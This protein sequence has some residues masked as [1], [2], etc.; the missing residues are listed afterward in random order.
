MPLS[1]EERATYEWQM[2]V[3]GFGESGQEKLKAA[4]VLV[5]RVGGLGGI[6]AYELAAAGIGE[7]VIAH[8]G[9]S[10]P[11]DLNRQLLQTHAALGK[12]RVTTAAERLRD[13]NP[14]L[15][16]TA[17]DENINEENAG[18]LIADVDIVVDCAPL[19]EE[20]FAMNRAA[21][22]HRKPLV[23]CAMYDLEATLTSI[24]PGRTP[25]LAC[26]H[27]EAPPAWKREFPVFGAVSGSVGCMAAMEAIKI[28]AG[29]GE[30]MLGRLLRYDLREMTFQ[31]L[32]I[33]RDDACP[34]CS[35][36]FSEGV[37]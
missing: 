29:F 2:W 10:R 26:L 34:V 15:E 23:E 25:C 27:P 12:K 33:E 30:P 16:I 5:S 32:T 19:F 13:L 20:R 31:T 21:V 11:P 18:R 35:S 9:N 8:A 28:I 7:L 22:A 1:D 14:R 4:R 36:L 24:V 37:A 6:V 17:V 3:D